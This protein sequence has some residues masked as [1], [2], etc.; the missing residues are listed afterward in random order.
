MARHVLL[1]NIEHNDLKVI[2]HYSRDYGNSV[3]S[4][5]VFPTEFAN[6]QREYPIL[7]QKNPE[8]GAY[9][10]IALVGFAKDENLF[11]VEPEWQANYVPCIMAR[12]PFLIG[13]R[14]ND[15]VRSA[16]IHVDLDD[17]RVNRSAGEPVFLE[18]GGNTPYLE[19]IS[20][21]LNAI[22]EGLAASQAMFDA[23]EALELIEPVNIDVTINESEIY[24]LNS[25]Y[26]VNA[27]RFAGL[28]GGELQQLNH[29]GW[30]QAAVFVVASL[31]NINHLIELK[32][33]KIAHTL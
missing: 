19:R 26:T 25:F 9:Q 30:L 4:V 29:S 21:V 13:F 33:R 24:N 6:I 3:N 32:R 31:G 27:E 18:H 11:L 7:F 1:N 14:D 22:H 10:S 15:G 5:L 17:P 2:N 20:T 28:N 8:T 16:V 23:F 12:G